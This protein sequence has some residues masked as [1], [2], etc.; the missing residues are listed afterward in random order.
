MTPYSVSDF[1][2]LCSGKQGDPSKR[3]RDDE[4]GGTEQAEQHKRNKQ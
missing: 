3:L 4:G 2:F 1:S